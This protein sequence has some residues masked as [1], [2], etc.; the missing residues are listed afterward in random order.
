MSAYPLDSESLGAHLETVA[1]LTDTAQYL[2]SV[3]PSLHNLASYS[4]LIMTDCFI[5]TKM[6]RS[7]FAS[8]LLLNLTV[9]GGTPE[10]FTTPSLR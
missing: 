10:A 1:I 8:N 9:G 7:D 2:I 6:Y 5:R 4:S 3:N